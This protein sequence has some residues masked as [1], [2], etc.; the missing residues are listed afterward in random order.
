M[1]LSIESLSI[2]TKRNS[3]ILDHVSLDVRAGEFVVVLGP[4]GAGKSSLLKAIT[5]DMPFQ[6]GRIQINDKPLDRWRAKELA[7]VRAVMPQKVVLEF[8]FLVSEVV[9]MGR[10][11]Y[12]DGIDDRHIIHH[13]MD[14]MHTTHLKQRLYPSLSGGEQQRVQ[15]AR[16]LAQIWHDSPEQTRY[17][18]LDECTSAL[19]PFYQHHIFHIL[20]KLKQCDIGMI[21]VVH[22]LNLAAQYADKILLLKEGKTLAFGDKK[23][24]LT[25]PLLAEAYN[26]DVELIAQKKVDWHYIVTNI[27]QEQDL[28]L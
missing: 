28:S 21:A 14:L 1:M 2:K 10:S 8:P 11:A 19:D 15:L 6:Q 17:M 23:D 5:G 25:A 20:A 13:C 3:T 24:V 9:A 26:I 22:D 16:V 4:N 12:R 18:L 7:A 27:N